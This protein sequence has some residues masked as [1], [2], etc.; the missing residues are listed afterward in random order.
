MRV[1]QLADAEEYYGRAL[2]IARGNRSAAAQY[3]LVGARLPADQ[4]DEAIEVA[5]EFLAKDP[6]ATIVRQSR[7]VALTAASRWP[8]A[9]ADWRIVTN[10]LT[11]PKDRSRAAFFAGMTA[12]RAGDRADA[13][14]FVP[15]VAVTNPGLA[16]VLQKKTA[17]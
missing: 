16:A 3:T 7:A 2:T 4:R 13:A 17:R 15:I 6:Q 11:I 8:E 12:Y 14:S 1:G 5:S 9:A 10:E